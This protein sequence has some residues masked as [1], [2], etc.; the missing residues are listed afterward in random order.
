M[1][2]LFDIHAHYTDRRFDTEHPGGA[3]ALLGEIMPRPVGYIINV[4]TDLENAGEVIAQAARHDGM[5]A[6]VGI[7]PGDINEGADLESEMAALSRLLERASERKIVSIGEIGLDYYWEPYDRE[8]QRRY[9]EAQMSL[10]ADFHLPVQVH[11]RE[12][13]GDCLEIIKKF[14]NVRGVFHSFSGSPEMA[15]ELVRLGWYISFSGVLTFRNARRAVETASILPAERILIETDC[16]Y[17]APHPHR[18]KLNHSG[19]IYHT[20]ER[21]GE[22]RNISTKEAA[23]LTR[24]NAFELFR[25]DIV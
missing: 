11:D 19:L 2:K 20:A 22:L 23:C 3:E 5:Y 14:P 8:A 13:H 18:G 4:S 1:E 10:A 6:A 21:L 7:H 16:P 25:L 15:A 17:L 9:F 12:A 24:A